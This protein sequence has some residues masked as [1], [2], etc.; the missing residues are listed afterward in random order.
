MGRETRDWKR[1]ENSEPEEVA[2]HA[3]TGHEGERLRVVRKK[4]KIGSRC[5]EQRNGGGCEWELG[6]WDLGRLWEGKGF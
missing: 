6:T 1:R 2:G 3:F 5:E 4:T